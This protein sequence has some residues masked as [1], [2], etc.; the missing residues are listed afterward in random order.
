[1]TNELNSNTQNPQTSPPPKPRAS[2]AEQDQ[3]IANNITDAA[4][5]IETAKTDAE[6]RP[7]LDAKGYDGAELDKG[8]AFHAA[9]QAAFNERQ[10]ASGK[11]KEATAQAAAAEEA[12]RRTYADFRDTSRAVFLAKADQAKLGLNGKVPSD[13][14]KFIT[15]ARASYNAAKDEPYASKLA[16]RGFKASDNTNAEAGLQTLSTA[17]GEQTKAIAEAQQATKNRDAAFAALVD[18]VGEFKRIA[19]VA[20]RGNPSLAR[21]LNL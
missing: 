4:Q 13:L 2:R 1:M 11:Q 17:G 9:A 18:W 7:F 19:K 8:A 6:L 12:A 16:K 10:K 14:Q 21:K 3:I 20:L 15:A 5:M